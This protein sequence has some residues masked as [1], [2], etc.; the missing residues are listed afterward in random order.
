MKYL[1]YLI[2]FTSVLLSSQLVLNRYEESDQSVDVYHLIDNQPIEC[3]KEYGE[4]FVPLISCILSNPVKIDRTQRN[5]TYFTISF[6]N[7]KVIFKAKA[8]AKILPVNDKLIDASVVRRQKYYRHWVIIGAKKE[9][10]IFVDRG[11]KRFNFPLEF[12]KK[13]PPYIGSLDLNGEPVKN[14]KGA[15]YLAK[16]KR[17]YKQKKYDALIKLVEQY[18]S[19]HRDSFKSDID[20]YRL[21]ALAELAAKDL[22]MYDT[23]ETYATAWI[24]QNPSSRH[25]TEAY[26]FL[27]RSYL[28]RGRLKLAEKYLQLLKSGF[29]NDKYTQLAQIY[30][31]ET[32]YKQKKRRK[33]ALK[34]FKDIL[35][36]T[37]DIHTASVA[38][39][40]AANAYLDFDEPSKAKTYI[41]K[42]IKS[43]PDFLKED[44]QTSFKIAKKFAAFDDYDTA[45]QIA[46]ILQDVN[47]KQF[48]DE[49]LKSYAYWEEQKGDREKAIALYNKYLKIYPKGKN[50]PF[51][52][53]HL[54]MLMLLNEDANLTKKLSFIDQVLK[55][56]TQADIQKRALEEKAKL[57]IKL[58]RYDEVLKMQKMLSRYKLDKY[59]K[60]AAE[61]GAEE[62]LGK[63]AC[64]RAVAMIAEHNLTLPAKYD[65][66]LYLCYLDTGKFKDAKKLADHRLQT[67]NLHEK[68][69]WLYL[70]SRL[71]KKLDKNKK[72]IVV[73]DD[74]LKLSRML[75]EPKYEKI[76]YD[77]AEAYYNLRNYDDLML[78]IVKQI[79]KKFPNDLR[80]IDLFMKVIR[81]A[82]KKNDVMLQMNYAKKVLDLQKK[83]HIDTY[84]PKV[85]ILYAHTLMKTGQNRKALDV[86]LPLLRR[87]LNDK[88]KA[89]VLY[90]AGEISLALHKKREAI[91]FFTKCGE[92][93]QDSSWQKLCA[94]N[95]Q[96]LTEY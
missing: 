57:L 86:V 15:I 95:L 90:M 82:Q 22:S 66:Q 39:R 92:I 51:V 87:K 21:R 17:L 52:L 91:Q 24:D 26:M 36:S 38:A 42:I 10:E 83:Y 71:Y 93:V 53:R 43:N 27:I 68:L 84:S 55:R 46:K 80:N 88:E 9:P 23:L 1:I 85:D 60:E 2:S 48:G 81:Y 5:D 89:E 58:K 25:I 47:D 96:L 20:L 49:L 75:H 72:V 30:F 8:Y 32:I 11:K 61:K 79:E 59:V 13:A 76:L 77:I 19:M 7:N 67:K 73:G 50:K 35:F 56:Y 63:K 64:E 18:E 78:T 70:M 16:I 34:I 41:E 69:H 44:Y 31:A 28:G 6:Q 40:D 4:G 74:I 54:D 12:T 33:E 14:K 45:L 3:Q 62:A 29:G 37:K 65:E 94:E